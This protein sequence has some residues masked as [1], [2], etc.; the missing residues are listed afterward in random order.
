MGSALSRVRQAYID[1]RGEDAWEASRRAIADFWQAIETGMDN[2]CLDYATVRL[3]Q[4]G[5]PVCG[6]EQKIVSDLAAQGIANYRILLKLMDRGATLE[7]TE[8]PELL[9]KEY[10]LIMSAIPGSADKAQAGPRGDAR[11]AELSRLLEQRDLFIARRIDASL[12]DGETGILFLGALHSA[13][14][15]LPST[16]RV[17]TLPELLQSSGALGEG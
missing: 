10:G 7:G 14:G 6:I 1:D 11:H 9:R 13:V 15:K 4:D 2:L 12:L 16:I 3:Y 5:L 17:M 8:D